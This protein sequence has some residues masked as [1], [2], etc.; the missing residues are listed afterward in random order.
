MITT[1]VAEARRPLDGGIQLTPGPIS[2]ARGATNA[3]RQRIRLKVDD[4]GGWTGLRLGRAWAMRLPRRDIAYF[5]LLEPRAWR[6]QR[7][8]GR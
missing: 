2:D 4:G 8:L 5:L 1:G 7:C 6:D 3:A